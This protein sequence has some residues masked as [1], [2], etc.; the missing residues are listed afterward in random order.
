MKVSQIFK[1]SCM[2]AFVLLLLA[3]CSQKQEHVAQPIPVKV[4]VVESSANDGGWRYSANIKPDV[5]VDMAF[6]VGGY[7]EEILQVS[8]ADGHPRNVQEGDFIKKGTILARVRDNEYRDKVAE[9]QAAFTQAKADYDRAAKL[10]ENKS[11][12]KAEYDA[13]YARFTASQARYDQAMQTLK[14][15][16]LAAPMDGFVLKRNIEVGTLL[17][18][19]MPAFI[20]ADTRSVKAIFGVP[21]VV[22]G[23]LKMGSKQTI[24]TEAIAGVEF[25]GRIT[26]IAPSADP[27]SRVFEVECKIP[28]PDNRLKAGMIAALKIS[29]PELPAP[30]MLV[31]LNAIVRSKDDPKGYAVFVVEEQEGKPIAHER[32]VQLGEVVGNSIS[33]TEGLHGGEKVIVTGATLVVEGQEVRI[34]P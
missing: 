31:P 5:Q 30:A 17:G 19:G 28:N 33:V 8:G 11:I 15:C 2:A 14:D 13:A 32:K 18:P 22:V 12:A 20:L 26:R 7:I 34:I 21:D 1:I 16:A 6:K 23:N 29:K 24:T 27:N 25:H 10:F 4:Q 3:G 9:A